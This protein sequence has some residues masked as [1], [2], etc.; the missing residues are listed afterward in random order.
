[1]ECFVYRSPRRDLL[2][3]YVPAEGDFSS[4]PGELM[5]TFGEPELVMQLE[6]T[7]DRQL[8]RATG[9]EVI[10][11]LQSRGFYLQTPPADPWL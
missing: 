8:V 3:L 11:A 9:R 2:Y 7:P 5:A 4:V 1:M 6:L 10:E